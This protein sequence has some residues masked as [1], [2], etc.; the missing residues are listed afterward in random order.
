[1]PLSP[2][3]VRRRLCALGTHL[4]GLVGAARG[5][6]M[7]AVVGST[8]A[9][10]IYAVDRVAD[11]ALVAWFERHW[12]GVRIVSEGLEEVVEVGND[13]E[14]TV[15]VDTIDGTRGLMYDKRS[16]WSLAAVAPTGGSLADVVSAVMTELPTSK[17]GMADQLS[18]SRGGGLQAE[19]V[20]LADGTATPLPVRPATASDLEHGYGGLVK[21]FRSGKPQL[22][23]LE[24]ELFDRLGCRHVFDDQYISTGGQLYELMTGHDRFVADLRP[25]IGG[26]SLACHP[27]DVCTSVLLE[28]AGGVVTDPWGRPLDAPLDTVSPVAWVGYANR[29]L[30]EW[31]GPVLGELAGEL[32]AR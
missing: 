18:G 5:G 27:Y 8:Q 12:P 14:W 21:F 3:E 15:I 31:I 6:E 7:A 22:A 1:V 23:M 32:R 4:R 26:T 11:D 13:P 19:R 10:V 9:D 29:A 16:A 28:E 25:L 20:R 17:A 2:D 24:A 30:A